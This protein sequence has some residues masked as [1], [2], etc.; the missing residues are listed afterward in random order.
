MI[1]VE[2]HGQIYTLEKTQTLSSTKSPPAL[3]LSSVLKTPATV[4][5]QLISLTAPKLMHQ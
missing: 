1:Y 4:A 2:V 5:S 3:Q